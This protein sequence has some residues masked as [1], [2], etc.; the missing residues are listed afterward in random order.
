VQLSQLI[1]HVQDRYT[2]K[3][4]THGYYTVVQLYNDCV[5]HYTRKHALALCYTPGVFAVHTAYASIS[6]RGC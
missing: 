6:A 4:I 1:T 3:I 5:M 2:G